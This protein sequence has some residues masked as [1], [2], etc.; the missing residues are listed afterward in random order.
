MRNKTKI[1]IAGLVIL[2]AIS[3]IAFC[4]LNVGIA[5]EPGMAGGCVCVSFDKWDMDRADKIVF[6][7]S[8]GTSTVTDP[9]LIRAFCNETLAGTY[10]DYCCAHEQDPNIE[11]Q[12]YRQ[13][14]LIRS[15]RYVEN[16]DAVVYNADSAHWVL[17]GDEGHAFLSY[18]L[19][20]HIRQLMCLP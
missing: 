2:C 4:A 6:E 5:G 15:M 14:R 18:E 19:R 16:H 7:F 8:G 13:D 3:L 12:I 11:I 1:V 20:R 17:F 9:E 10:S